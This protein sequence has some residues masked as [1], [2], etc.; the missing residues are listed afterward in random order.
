LRY[1]D[2]FVRCEHGWRFS[3]RELHVD[4][5]ADVAATD[6]DTDHDTKPA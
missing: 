1:P 6:H 3:R 5:A 2:T 4:R